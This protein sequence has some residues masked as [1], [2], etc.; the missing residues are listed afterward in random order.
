MEFT[1]RHVMENVI[2]VFS[3]FFD[4]DWMD[5]CYDVVYPFDV[6]VFYVMMN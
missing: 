3:L 5:G 1:F 2:D 4:D 6:D